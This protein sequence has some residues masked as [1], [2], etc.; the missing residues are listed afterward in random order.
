LPYFKVV[1]QRKYDISNKLL[2]GFTNYNKKRWK[3]KIKER[4]IK[5]LKHIEILITILPV[6]LEKTLWKESNDTKK[7]HQWCKWAII[8]RKQ[9]KEK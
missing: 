3:R 8:M 4:K 9:D 5:T 7:D 1:T 2:N 6:L